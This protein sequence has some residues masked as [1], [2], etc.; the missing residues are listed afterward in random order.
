MI[1]RSRVCQNNC[2]YLRFRYLV[3]FSEN[4][5]LEQFISYFWLIFVSM[6][7]KYIKT[8][9]KWMILIYIELLVRPDEHS[10]MS[11]HRGLFS[12][13]LCLTY[14]GLQVQIW[15]EHWAFDPHFST[16]VAVVHWAGTK[17]ISKYFFLLENC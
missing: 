13:T 16:T 14:P 8:Q 12:V 10:L 7:Q 15:F 6:M 3:L 1:Y 4:Y 11:T 5:L 9:I 2:R 17:K